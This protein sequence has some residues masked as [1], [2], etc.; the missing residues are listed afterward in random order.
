MPHT[1]GVINTFGYIS[2][3]VS[4]LIWISKRDKDVQIWV[5]I[6]K[7]TD[8]NFTASFIAFFRLMAVNRKKRTAENFYF[9]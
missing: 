3:T 9:N 4:L 1:S 6:I 7:K 5:K 2:F 8:K